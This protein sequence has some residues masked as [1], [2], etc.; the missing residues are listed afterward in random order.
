[1]SGFH[2]LDFS[3]KSCKTEGEGFHLDAKMFLLFYP[4][5]NP[6]S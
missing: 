6:L 5:P 1:M 2:F 4:V 3:G